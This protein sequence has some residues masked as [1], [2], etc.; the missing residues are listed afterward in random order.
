VLRALIREGAAEALGHVP[1]EA[2]PGALRTGP[3]ATAVAAVA[4]PVSTPWP[5]RPVRRGAPVGA[6]RWRAP[7]AA[8]VGV[9][10]ALVTVPARPAFGA[11]AIRRAAWAFRTAVVVPLPFPGKGA[12]VSTVPFRAPAASLSIAASRT[13]VIIACRAAI[14]GRGSTVGAEA[15]VA[16]T[17]A[18]AVASRRTGWPVRGTTAAAERA[19]RR[20]SHRPTTG[21]AELAVTSRTAELAIT[22]RTAELAITPRTA[23]FAI[24]SRAAELAI[25]P[26]AAEFAIT[27]LT[28]GIAAGVTPEFPA[29]VP[30]TVPVTFTRTVAAAGPC[31]AP[32]VV[33]GA[34][35]RR[36][37][38]SAFATG[39]NWA[40]RAAARAGRTR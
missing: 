4:E 8:V 2:A 40:T 16:G 37:T 9:T 24:T 25:T 15:P 35:S 36:I 29:C 39:G 17:P 5:V 20:T 34:A 13:S 26:R 10:A 32:R 18:A 14:S 28:A 3:R 1:A 38:V 27:S 22:S 11:A 31:A 12:T 23:E 7:G 30:V 19:S 33:T 21:L 6:M